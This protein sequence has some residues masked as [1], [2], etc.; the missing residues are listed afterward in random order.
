MEGNSD[1]CLIVAIGQRILIHRTV[2][3]DFFEFCFRLCTLKIII[4]LL[5]KRGLME[6]PFYSLKA[7]KKTRVF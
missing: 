1:Q 2:C 4:V 6:S 3:R 5:P 7:G